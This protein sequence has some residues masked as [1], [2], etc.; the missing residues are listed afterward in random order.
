MT[1]TN[2]KP[3][4]IEP[5]APDAAPA[6]DPAGWRALSPEEKAKELAHI[7]VDNLNAAVDK[8]TPTA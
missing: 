6:F 5:T 7:F 1:M 3:E 2:A 4:P 8:G